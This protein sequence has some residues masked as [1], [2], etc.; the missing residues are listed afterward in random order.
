MC[1]AT[2]LGSARLR[3]DARGQQGEDAHIVG[4]VLLM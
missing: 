3:E 1:V 4:D 2:R